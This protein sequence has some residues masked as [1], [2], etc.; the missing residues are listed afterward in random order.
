MDWK[1]AIEQEWAALGRIVALLFAL[2]GLAERAAGRSPA[3]RTL[4]LW[5]LRQAETVARDFV[6]DGVDATS[7]PVLPAGTA[8]ADALRLAASL[9][10]LAQ[11]IDRHAGQLLALCGRTGGDPAASPAGRMP[12][13]R[14]DF[15]VLGWRAAFALGAARRARAPDSS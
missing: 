9:R 3:V 13:L 12:A 4:V 7:M 15:A 11:E 2:A 10:A 14:D 6:A 8:P 1:R 5:F